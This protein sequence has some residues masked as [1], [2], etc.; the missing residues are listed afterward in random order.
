MTAVSSKVSKPVTINVVTG[1]G[2]GGHYAT[3][4]ALRAVAQQR[5]LPWQFRVTDMDDIMESITQQ[6]EAFN[7]YKL[8][9]SSVSDLYNQMLKRGWTWLWPLQ[10]RL[11][12]LLVKLNY[13]TGVEFFEGYWREQ[14]PDL[15]ISVVTMCNKVLWEALQ[16][17]KPGTPY[18]T[19]PIDFAD[20]PPGFWFE[21]DT[22]SFAVCGTA[23]AVEQARTIGV[24]ASCMVPTSGMVIHPRFYRPVG[25]DSPEERLRQR[26]AERHR[27]GLAPHKLT[28]LVMFGGNGS[29]VMVE[30]AKRLESY[31]EELQ[32]IYLCGRNEPLMT[33]LRQLPNQQSRLIVGFTQDIP[34]YM[35][36]A[37]FFIGKPGPGSLS[38]AL[39]MQLP[40]ITACN[41]ATLVHER[42]NAEWVRSQDVGI[43][44][45][46]FSH[47]AQA[48]DQFLQ[49]DILHRYQTNVAAI[50]NRAVF[51]VADFIQQVLAMP[52]P[53]RAVVPLQS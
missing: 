34:E 40:V 11:N 5:N 10:M 24:K 8:L 26:T 49:P 21:P 7:L 31:F 9:G 35:R 30:I 25:C 48:V 53:D 50:N 32:L 45:K 14:Q 13:K 22:D 36:L 43:V 4:H 15:V 39:V 17:A 29:Q 28:G 46:R 16:R 51:E 19:L 47:I 44:L 18:I 23:K 52:S 42:Y 3:Y 41:A 6:G 12:K 27:L 20:Y 2:G 1:K 38:E 33:A 37:D